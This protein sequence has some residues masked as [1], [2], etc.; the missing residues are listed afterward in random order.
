MEFILL[1]ILTF[2]LRAGK[3]DTKRQ[4]VHCPAAWLAGRF[5]SLAQPTTSRAARRSQP[6][7]WLVCVGISRAH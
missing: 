1:G 6:G 3:R 2:N 7:Q 4:R 5:A